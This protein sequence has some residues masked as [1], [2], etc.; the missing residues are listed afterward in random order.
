VPACAPDVLGDPAGVITGM[1]AEVERTLGRAAIADTVAGVAG[2]RAKRRRLAQALLDRPALLADGRSPAPR[3]AGDLLL[4]LR[5][6]GATGIAAPSCAGCGKPLRTM[7]RRGQDW[8]CGA[9]GPEPEPCAACGSIRPVSSRDRDGRPRCGRCPP[10]SGQDPAG[11]VAGLVAAIDPA[12]P[13]SAVIAAVNAAAP[14]AG[15]RRRLAWALQDRPELLTGAGAQAAEPAVL[16]LIAGLCA[17]GAAGVVRPPCPHCGRVIA[18][19]RPIGG[20]RLCR[21]CVARSRAVPC[22]RCGA[23]RETAARDAGGRPLC[24]SCLVADPANQE[25]C[26]GCGRRRTVSVRTPAGPLCPS[27]RPTRTLTCSICGRTAPCEISKV[28][29]QPWCKACQQRWAPCAGC[30][31]TLP[32]RGGTAGEPLCSTCL[33]PGPGFWRSCPGCGQ[34]GR[35]TAGR[36]VRCG[37]GERLHE[38]LG[39]AADGI[40]PELQALYQALADT[41]RPDT[42]ASWLAGSAAAPIL[43]NLGTGTPLTHGL[44]DALPAGKPVEHLRSVLVSIGTLPPRDEQMNRLERWIATAVTSRGPGEQELLHRYAV[45][46]LLRRLRRRAGG[47]ETTHNQLVAVRQ[48]VRAAIVLLDWLTARDL[49]LATC[50]QG[51]LDNWMTSPGTTH[52]REAGHFVRWAR[53]QELTSLD[54]PA[55]KWGG[56]ART[57]DTEARWDQARRLLHDTALRPEDRVAGLLVLLYAQGP[58]A[59]SRLTLDHVQLTGG[60]VLLRLGREPVV[61]PE[62]LAGLTRQL[63]ADRHGHAAIG[64]QGT[65]RWLFPGG[66]P[67]RPISSYQLNERLRQLGLHPGQDRSTALFQLAADLPAALLARMLGIHIT[68]AVAWQRASSGDWTSYA[69]DVS[70]RTRT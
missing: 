4:A 8:Y 61:L 23:L 20:L 18:L 41:E 38:L 70:R 6:A 52:R 36:C 37:L 34:P 21:N 53:A 33:R 42:A 63:T 54:F 58:S 7:Q 66:Q 1:V 19:A 14:G 22:S 57:I 25:E 9:C 12:L 39:D 64:D 28:T 40:R 32:V 49:T 30:G 45:W 47:G 11:I 55:T 26:A 56:P 46:H 27:C 62:P 59:I 29:G 13:A 60:K 43:R 44:L 31:Q 17:A 15:Q 65:S 69:A 16:R 3:A 24:P 35:L 10:G 67:G 68:V 2:G 48:H 5:A 50:G 51:D